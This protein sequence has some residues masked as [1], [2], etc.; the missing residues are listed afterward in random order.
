MRTALGAAADTETWKG[1]GSMVLPGPHPDGRPVG[2]LARASSEA[3]ASQPPCR[4]F[5]LPPPPHGV[6]SNH[7]CPLLEST[8]S[9]FTLSSPSKLASTR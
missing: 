9:P 8:G 4:L 6:S 3:P 1:V 5:L 7:P 2:Q